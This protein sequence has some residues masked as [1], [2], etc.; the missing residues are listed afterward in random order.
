MLSQIKDIFGLIKS[1]TLSLVPITS[2]WRQDSNL[3]LPHLLVLCH[4]L[5]ASPVFSICFSFFLHRLSQD[6]LWVAPPSLF[7]LCP[8][9]HWLIIIIFIFRGLDQLHLAVLHPRKLAVY[10]VSGKV[11]VIY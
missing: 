10:S 11:P 8:L 4:D 7:L 1:L 2:W 5:N 6:D 9:I 3:I